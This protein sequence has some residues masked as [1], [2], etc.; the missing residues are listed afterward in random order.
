[1]IEVTDNSVYSE[2][3]NITLQKGESLQIRAANRTRP[4]IYLLD[5]KKN[6]PD[7]LTVTSKDGGSFSLDGLLITG[8]GVYIE[9]QLDE[10]NIRHCTLVPGWALHHDCEPTN[11]REASLE[12]YQTEV[13]CNIEHSILGPIGVYHD[14]VLEDPIRL[15]ISDSIL[16]ATNPTGIVLSD[17]EDSYAHVRLTIERST[18]IGRVFAHAID[19]AE[20]SIFTSPVS[21]ARRQIGCMRFCYVPPESRTPRRYNCQPDLAEKKA[22]ELIAPNKLTKAQQD[23]EI[24]VER[25][26]VRP[27]FNSLRYGTPRYCQLAETCAIEI[28]RGAHDESEMGVFHDLFQPQREANLRARLNEYTPASTEAGIIFAS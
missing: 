4:T 18:V 25:L 19:L 15:R 21:V 26:R 3:L 24:L 1:V 2:Q 22:L 20:D 17:T 27:Q 28:R 10:V 7:A 6:R 12:L 23:Q 14:N 13:V 16:D 9:G 5:R 11:P 8:R